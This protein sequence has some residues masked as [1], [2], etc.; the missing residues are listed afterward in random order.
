[1]ETAMHANSIS[2]RR[3]VGLIAFVLVLAA[4]G[5]GRD[6]VRPTVD[7]FVLGQTTYAQVVQRMGEPRSSA[8]SLHNGKNVR[9][10]GY[11]YANRSG[12]PLEEGVNS[13]RG[14]T[15]FF[16]DDV[17]VGQQFISSFKSDNSNFD[18][19]QVERIKKGLTSRAEVIQLLGPPTASF[20]PPMVKE[21]SGEAIGYTYQAIRGGLFSGFKIDAK[22]LR[23]SFDDKGMASEID[24]TSRG[25]K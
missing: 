9:S 25:S 8:D 5:A 24:F 14:M 1:M 3:L 2:T 19:T 4:C 20:I 6:F 22:V 16:Y 7:S 13:A 15:Y 21:T 12:E 17:L 11:V 18:E 10:I 23:I